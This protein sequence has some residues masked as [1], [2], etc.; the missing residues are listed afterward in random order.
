[1]QVF[2][3]K[4]MLWTLLLT[5]V[6]RSARSILYLTSAWCLWNLCLVR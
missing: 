2:V 3:Q 6:L 4:V 5:W 1:M